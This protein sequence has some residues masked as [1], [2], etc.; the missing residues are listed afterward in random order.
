LGG[1]EAPS[2]PSPQ[3]HF[4]VIEDDD[5]SREAFCALIQITGNL[6]VGVENGARALDYLRCHAA[7]DAILLDMRMPVMDGWEF[8][9]IQCSDPELRSIPVLVI[10]AEDRFRS[11][12]LATGVAGFISKP[13]DPDELIG[14]LEVLA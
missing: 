1:R 6:A 14:A 4:L 2:N 5:D 9:Q 3:K 10:S 7:P 8:R 11:R 12:T 13:I